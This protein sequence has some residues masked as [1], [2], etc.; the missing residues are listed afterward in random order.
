M[1]VDKRLA[2]IQAVQTLS[3]LNRTATGK[4][5]T[6]VLDFVNEPD[7]IFEAFKPYYETTPVGDEVNPQK[8]YE[9]QAQLDE[10]QIYHDQEVE[11]FCKVFFKPQNTPGDHKVMNGIIDCA[12]SRFEDLAEEQQEEFRS[13]LVSFRNMY[14]FLSQIIPYQDSD[15][16]KLYTYLRFL[17]SKLPKHKTGPVYVFDDEVKLKY[18]RLQKISEGSISLRE[19][20]AEP[21]KGPGDGHRFVDLLYC[22]WHYS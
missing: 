2:G 19:G 5:D 6:F 12:V 22:H 15:L 11:S 9:L 13:L 1:Y 10:F 16:E 17:H 4:E 3:R 7:E 21:L 8:M 18:Y 20:D 14:G